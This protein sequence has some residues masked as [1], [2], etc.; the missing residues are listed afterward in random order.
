MGEV[1]DMSG[2]T[3]KETHGSEA[4]EV[5]LTGKLAKEEMGEFAPYLSGLNMLNLRD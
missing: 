2:V 5:Q 4:L 1:K 3:L